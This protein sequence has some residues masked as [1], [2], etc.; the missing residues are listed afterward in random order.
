L[1]I[2]KKNEWNSCWLECRSATKKKRKKKEMMMKRG[3]KGGE[4]GYEI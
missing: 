4:F 2:K 1:L 3:I